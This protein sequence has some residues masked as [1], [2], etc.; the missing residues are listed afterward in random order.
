[1]NLTLA[2]VQPSQFRICERKLRDVRAWFRPED[3][4]GFEPIPIRILDGVPVMTDGHTR[5]VAALLA[6]LET[7]PM[8]PE[9]DELDWEMY[10]RCVAAC[11]ERGIFRPADLVDRIVPEET[12]T[13]EWDRWC[14]RMQ[15]EV[16]RRRAAKAGEES[17]P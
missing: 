13:E 6:G 9:E 17:A 7:V 14:D 2:D 10:R 15:A 12:Y 4:S 11:R 8:A 3:L 5:A 1:M 16:L